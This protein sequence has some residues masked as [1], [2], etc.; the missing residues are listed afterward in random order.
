MTW[1][2]DRRRNEDNRLAELDARLQAVEGRLDAGK[3]R[4]D[5]L[6]AGL[7]ANTTITA[8]VN[9]RTKAIEEQLAPISDAW[10]TLQAGLRVLGG[11]GKVGLF[12]ARHWAVIVG[13]GAFVWAWT[14]G[15]TL[16]DAIKEFWKGASK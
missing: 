12:L 2:G 1:N 7:A 4:F 15:A 9:D 16:E 11:I 10:G 13:V 6:D 3:A 5:S 14:H 8:Q